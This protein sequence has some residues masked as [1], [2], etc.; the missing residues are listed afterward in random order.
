MAGSSLLGGVPA[1]PDLAAAAAGWRDWL[2]GERRASPH[3]LAAYTRDLT[4][5]L[6]FL[7]THLG[8]AASLDD[9]GRLAPADFRAYLAARA[10]RGAAASATAR[11]MSV[12]RG[13]F[14]YLDRAG[15]VR[16]AAIG[17]VRSPRLPRAVPRPLSTGEAG[18]VLAAAADTNANTNTDRDSWVAKRDLALLTLLYGCGL[19]IG[20]ALGLTRREAPGGKNREADTLVITGKG[21]KQRMVP[22]LPVVAAAINDYLDACPYDPG[23]EG[24]LFLGVRGGPLAAGVVQ[25]SMRRIRAALGL[26]ETATPHALRHSFAT[27]LLGAGADLRS[28]Q[29]LL[30]HAS[31]STTQ[32]YTEVDSVRLARIYDDAHPRAE[33]APQGGD[34][35]IHREETGT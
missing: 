29:E 33:T 10:S 15:L 30:G 13:F 11:A 31:L 16:N 18:S 25:K 1:G 23:P 17:A 4:D 20:E 8:G 5:F 14:R 22:V 7:A 3:T 24:P 21:R 28:I 32:R 34:R 27:H 9:L 12:L 6:A 35:N 2:A 26:A 19:R